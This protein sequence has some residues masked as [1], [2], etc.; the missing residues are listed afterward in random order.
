MIQVDAETQQLNSIEKKIRINIDELPLCLLFNLIFLGYRAIE[1]YW[2]L[3]APS[4]G[5][6]L[7]KVEL[8][9]TK[10]R[11]Q[12]KSVVTRNAYVFYRNQ[13]YIHSSFTAYSKREACIIPL[14]LQTMKKN[15]VEKTFVLLDLTNRIVNS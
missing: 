6:Y 7:L 9:Y 5:C 1:K 10:T 4:N 8:S 11:F 13:T 15:K 12:K 2:F 14:K 3:I